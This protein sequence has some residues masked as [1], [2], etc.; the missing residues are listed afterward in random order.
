MTKSNLDLA[1]ECGAYPVTERL[2]D[3]RHTIGMEFTT[4]QLDAF[5]ER[6]RAEANRLT[7]LLAN[8]DARA[9]CALPADAMIVNK[10][11]RELREALAQPSPAA[12]ERKP[13][14]N[15]QIFEAIK[16]V[17]LVKNQ[18]SSSHCWCTSY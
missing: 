18:E 4:A 5:A 8:W 16:A 17:G 6:I 11:A 1:R 7:A 3:Q 14:T 9:L 10:M 13:L 12:V 2:G 15:A